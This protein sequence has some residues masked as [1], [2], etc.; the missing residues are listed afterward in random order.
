M[1][2]AVLAALFIAGVL[3]GCVGIA[4]VFPPAAFVAAGAT[5]VAVALTVEV[6]KA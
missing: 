1:P 6:R 5:C 4:L 2:F 3:L